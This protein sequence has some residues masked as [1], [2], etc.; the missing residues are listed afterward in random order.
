MKALLDPE[1]PSL[2]W[3][4]RH[5]RAPDTKRVRSRSQAHE[6][7]VP[8]HV[9]IEAQS[10]RARRAGAGRK[11]ERKRATNSSYVA[12]FRGLIRCNL[13]GRKMHP[14]R[15]NG[16]TRYQC[17]ARDVAPGSALHAE[18]PVTVN[19]REDALKKCVDIEL[20]KLFASEHRDET[21]RT[22]IESQ[23]PPIIDELQRRR[24]QKD[25]AD[26][27]R[28]ARN[29]V[30]AV[31]K[32]GGSQMLLEA[33]AK[34]EKHLAELI[35]NQT[36]EAE[37]DLLDE[38]EVASWLDQFDFDIEEMLRTAEAADLYEL[39]QA[40]N[41]TL[42]YDANDEQVVMSVGPKIRW[43]PDLAENHRMNSERVRG[44]T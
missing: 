25:I 17:R 40:M 36:P 13:C 12:I 18:H 22:L 14:F 16:T 34:A 32:S 41:L 15:K 4:L 39:H 26:A 43:S 24:E 38:P 44:G 6:P 33:L 3:E 31:T 35:A 28:D 11:T 27:Q 42:N 2:G 37:T 19:I 20:L 21:L 5:R 10:V 29:L 8:M 30:E 7:I 9:F 1:N 23:D